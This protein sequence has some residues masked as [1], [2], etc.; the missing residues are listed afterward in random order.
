MWLKCQYVNS[1]VECCVCRRS[2]ALVSAH[3]HL[4]LCDIQCVARAH[5]A[6]PHHPRLG[7]SLQR[8]QYGRRGKQKVGTAD[9]THQI[10]DIS[11]LLISALLISPLLI[12]SFDIIFSLSSH[13]SIFSSHSLLFVYLGVSW[14][15]VWFLPFTHESVFARQRRAAGGHKGR[16]NRQE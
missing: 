16:P 6:A 7:L 2:L 13:N 8:H 10:I 11:A 4:R 3:L 5:L 14:Q 9:T 12:Y 1:C 15:W